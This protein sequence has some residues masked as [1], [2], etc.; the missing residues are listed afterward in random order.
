MFPE[1]S[2]RKNNFAE[3]RQ[4][5]SECGKKSKRRPLNDM[6]RDKLEEVTFAPK[7]GKERQKQLDELYALLMKSAK[8]GGGVGVMA[9]KEILDRAY[10]K[11]KSNIDLNVE[12]FTPPS[13]INVVFHSVNDKIK[14]DGEE[15]K[16]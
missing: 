8:K 16:I 9:I 6:W 4:L 14:E 7:T 13:E 11:A 15:E 10:G 2:R 3:N 1:A 5:A 12:G